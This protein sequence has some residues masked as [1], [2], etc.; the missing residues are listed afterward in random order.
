MLERSQPISGLYDEMRNADGTPRTHWEYLLRSLDAMGPQVLE[1]RAQETRRLLRETGVTYNVYGDPQG[2]ER[3][4]ELDLIPVLMT[5]Q[6]WNEVE[7]ALIQRAE[8]LDLILADVY[9]PQKLI[10]AGLLPPELIFGHSGFLFPCHAGLPPAVRHL[11]LYAADLARA[12]SG[13]LLVIGD[14][15]Q[16]PSGAG[17]ALENRIVLSRIFPSLYRD[18][19]VHRLALF[20]RALRN[21]LASLGARRS[22]N[23]RVVL[24]TPGPENETY[25]EHSYL[26]NYLGYTLVQGSDLTIRDGAVC[27]KTLGGLQ[28]VDVIV[29]RVD[30]DF[31]DPLELRKDS[32]LGIPGLLQAARTGAV[33]VS[34]PLGSGLLEN[35]GLMAFLPAIARWFLGQDLR[36]P[37]VE[38]WWCG[39]ERDRSH[40][41]ANLE[42]L[43]IKPVFPN[44]SPEVVWGNR[45]S[46]A[47]LEEL[48]A[49]IQARPHLY[50]GQARAALSTAPTL[51]QGRLEP[52]PMVLRSYLVARDDSYVVMPGG[53]TRVSPVTDD[54]FVSN[55][56]GG[57]G[58]DTW[59]LASEQ[60]NTLSLLPQPPVEQAS[61]LLPSEVAQAS[62]VLQGADAPRRSDALPARAVVELSREG[63]D[64]PSRVAD[65]LFWLG[66]YAERTEAHARLIREVLLRL[67]DEDPTRHDPLS[68]LLSAVTHQ[69][70]T[71]P[72]FV[73]PGAEQ[74]FAAPEQELL[75][76]MLDRQRIGSLRSDIDALTHC[77]WS[78]RDRLSEDTWR[79]ITSLDDHLSPVDL[80]E[81]PQPEESLENLE[82]VILSLAAFAGLSIE[83]MTRG[84]GFRFIDIGRRIERA[85]AMIGLLRW[86]L[87]RA[88]D[89]RVTL[90]EA[91]LA[92][93]DSRMTY[94][95]R[96]RMEPQPGPVLDLLL[97]DDGN[98]RSIAYQLV[99]LRSLVAALPNAIDPVR[100]GTPDAL[101]L[102]ALA[103]LRTADVESFA[104]LPEA[105]DIREA[106]DRLLLRLA[107]HL[108][109]L[110]EIIGQTYFSHT[111]V[112]QQL[113]EMQ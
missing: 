103:A 21:M 78:V 83:S 51:V 107:G 39:I 17:Y 85:L 10:R 100:P 26:A 96:Y 43:V 106:L 76:V 53:L 23:P 8:L 68:I 45:L 73:G 64:V 29:R 24:L 98:P 59:V 11:H 102:D 57:I 38:T 5:S 28:P 87:T 74:A 71:Y 16:A 42:H 58:K 105:L 56:R 93:A 19:H 72:G 32:L 25:F 109:A 18:S 44:A 49:R 34:N 33:A 47:E 9:G 84:Q 66:R 40:V 90:W 20:F 70:C 79:V 30:D 94:A 31:C 92:V 36:I 48:A 2:A 80:A 81:L 46:R 111:E 110:A 112:P 12:P 86:T 77:G 4:W 97:Q 15:A 67:L 14:R 3:L 104:S 50:V 69:T 37:S 35:P 6:E 88:G 55:Q 89:H 1:Q 91:L 7:S 101:V 82:R 22:D 54:E 13:G 95:R 41:I 99:T 52:R 108:T 113:V 61:R 27:L 60:V 62:R 75:A 65:N 63:G